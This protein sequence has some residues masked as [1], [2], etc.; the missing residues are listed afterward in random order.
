[1]TPLLPGI[2][3]QMVQFLEFL[4][5]PVTTHKNAVRTSRLESLSCNATA[6]PSSPVLTSV[7][8]LL[9]AAVRVPDHR[10]F[11]WSPQRLRKCCRLL[12]VFCYLDPWLHRNESG[13]HVGH[14]LLSDGIRRN[15]NRKEQTSNLCSLCTRYFV[16]APSVSGLN[17]L[18]VC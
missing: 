9:P 17:N 6:A 4:S 3:S 12:A 15:L 8:C 18:T 13:T 1:M 14:L 11:D 2:F 5:S 10:G 7:F 16:K